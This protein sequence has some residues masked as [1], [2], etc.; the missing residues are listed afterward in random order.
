MDFLDA[1]LMS[2]LA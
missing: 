2:Q 1:V